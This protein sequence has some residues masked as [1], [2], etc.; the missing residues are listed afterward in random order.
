MIA[1][2][3]QAAVPNLTLNRLYPDNDSVYQTTSQSINT[4]IVVRSGYQHLVLV[5]YNS[6]GKAFSSSTNFTVSATS[7]GGCF[8]VNAFGVDICSPVAGSTNP[9]SPSTITLTAGAVAQ[10]GNITAIR[11]YVDNLAVVTVNNTSATNSFQVNTPINVASGTHKLA[12]IG[13]QST[14]G[15]VSKSETFTVTNSGPCAPPDGQQ[16][17]VLCSPNGSAT[18]SSPL[19][20]S[21]GAYQMNGTIS[22]IRIYVDNVAQA[23]AQNPRSSNS[24]SITQSISVASGKHDLVVVAYPAGGG[25]FNA[26]QSIDVHEVSLRVPH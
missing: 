24:F 1:G 13:Y 18:F 9:S 7:N 12:V 14:G 6:A 22:S 26:S 8:P 25:S 3:R 10:S 23:T 17:V 19:T 16:G 2:E 21:A 15:T 11:A 4:S 5:S 20:V